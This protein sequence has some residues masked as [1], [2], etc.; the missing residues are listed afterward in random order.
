MKFHLFRANILPV[1]V[2]LVVFDPLDYKYLKVWLIFFRF[3]S[4]NMT[5]TPEIVGYP[6]TLALYEV[7]SVEGEDSAHKSGFSD[8][9]LN[10]KVHESPRMKNRYFLLI[11][12][13]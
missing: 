11:F 9:L 7:L 8:F 4:T 3:T 12:L 5:E 10:F 2:D 6:P 13:I 1:N